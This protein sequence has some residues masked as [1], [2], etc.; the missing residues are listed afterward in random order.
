MTAESA[1]VFSIIGL[2]ANTECSPGSLENYE[3]AQKDGNES[4]LDITGQKE[5]L[6]VFI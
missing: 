5:A 3:A 1:K 2:F 6:H 4:S